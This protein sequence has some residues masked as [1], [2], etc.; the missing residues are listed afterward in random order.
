MVKV[1]FRSQEE[2]YWAVCERVSRAA[3]AG[4]L[5]DS[6]QED[7]SSRG[8]HAWAKVPED[9]KIVFVEEA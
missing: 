3:E 6:M 9:W 2:V 1:T 8:S 4:F 7:S 5:L